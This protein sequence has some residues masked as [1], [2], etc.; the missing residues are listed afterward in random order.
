MG[1]GNRPQGTAKVWAAHLDALCI[2][3]CQVDGLEAP[4]FEHKI[5]H[6]PIPAKLPQQKQT[7]TR[8]PKMQRIGH[9]RKGPREANRAEGDNGYLYSRH[10]EA[11]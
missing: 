7:N 1:T 6:I 9:G 8:D 4:P 11:T 10:E 3:A 2:N 5:S